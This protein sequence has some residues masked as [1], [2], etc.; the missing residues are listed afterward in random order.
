MSR[1]PGSLESAT[2]LATL[3]VAVAAAT[4]VGRDA[5]VMVAVEDAQEIARD[6]ARGFFT[7][8]SG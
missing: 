6:T 7:R 5:V 2:A 4:V 1:T 3:A 8:Q